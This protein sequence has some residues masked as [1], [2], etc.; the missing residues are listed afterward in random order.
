M[1]K[2][3][4]A[5]ELRGPVMLLGVSRL[6]PS[7]LQIWAARYVSLRCASSYAPSRQKSLPWLAVPPT[8]SKSSVMLQTRNCDCV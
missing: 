4:N 6:L 5:G 3:G 7:V 8:L 2:T 1:S